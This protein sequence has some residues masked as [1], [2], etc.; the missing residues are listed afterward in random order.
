MRLLRS[1]E[2]GVARKENC[3]DDKPSLRAGFWGLSRIGP[4]WQVMTFIFVDSVHKK[5][6]QHVNK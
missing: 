4:E 6:E 5:I 2:F 3:W 1:T